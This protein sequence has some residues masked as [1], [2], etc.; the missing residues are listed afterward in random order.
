MNVHITRASRRHL[1]EPSAINSDFPSTDCHPTK[2]V[3]VM[4]S[5]WVWCAF[6]STG[7]ARPPKAGVCCG[8]PPLCAASCVSPCIR[9]RLVAHRLE[10]RIAE[11]QRRTFEPACDSRV[12]PLLPGT[13]ISI[14]LHVTLGTKRMTRL[15]SRWLAA[16]LHRMLPH[17]ETTE[18]R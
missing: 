14:P 3:S 9:R 7:A 15:E 2:S 18:V 16:T 11:P 4:A 10:K 5:R 12:G 6:Q 1:Q 13:L 17:A 8:Y